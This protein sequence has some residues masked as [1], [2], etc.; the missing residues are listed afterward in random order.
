[1]IE[2]NRAGKIGWYSFQID[3]ER[4]REYAKLSAAA[5][6]EWLEEANQFFN[7]ISDPAIKERWRLGREG[8]I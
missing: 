3:G 1:M 5:R 6:L 4:L 7:S 8:K 2:N